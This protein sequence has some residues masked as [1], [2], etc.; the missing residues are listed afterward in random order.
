M[1]RNFEDSSAWFSHRPLYLPLFAGLAPWRPCTPVSLAA[2]EGAFLVSPPPAIT[3]PGSSPSPL[4]CIPYS[5]AV[6]A[7]HSHPHPPAAVA[8][9]PIADP[10]DSAPLQS[11]LLSALSFYSPLPTHGTSPLLRRCLPD[12]G[13]FPGPVL[14]APVLPSS[15]SLRPSSLSLSP[16]HRAS[17]LFRSRSYLLFRC[18]SPC[19]PFGSCGRLPRPTRPFPRPQP[20]I[21]PVRKKMSAIGQ[22]RLWHDG[23]WW[24]DPRRAGISLAGPSP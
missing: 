11:A 10:F 1:P 7:S 6:R 22:A 3:S 15:S 8:S 23:Q 2:A 24:S 14:H 5:F 16:T 12:R 17:A 4:S 20:P 13:A 19:C 18:F 21:L 9:S